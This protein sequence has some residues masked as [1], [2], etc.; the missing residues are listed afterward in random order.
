LL[1]LGRLKDA[2]PV[3][4]ERRRLAPDAYASHANLGTLYT[5]TGEWSKALEAIDKALTIE[6][7]AHFGREKYHFQLVVFL[8]DVRDDP[9]LA[10]RENFLRI[11]V[12]AR[13]RLAGSKE[14]FARAGGDDAMFDAL[15]SM[16][17]VYGADRVSHVYFAL[18]EILALRGMTRLAWT[19]YQRAVELKHPR[20][21]EIREWQKRLS[22]AMKADYDKDPKAWAEKAQEYAGLP[23]PYRKTHPEVPF[24]DIYE[25]IS[26][27]YSRIT[28]DIDPEWAHY[29]RNAEKFTAWERTEIAGGLPVWSE[30]G[31]AKIYARAN[32]LRPR[33]KSPGVVLNEATGQ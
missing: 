12:D 32:E 5:F 6:P 24:R 31:L 7:K 19:A 1:K 11:A 27:T 8:R 23:L 9:S 14:V 3:M 16:I 20:A 17:S 4:L 30:E 15:V 26:A 25:P 10:E 29:R 21:K 18:G 2:E 22:L 13:D 28:R 33:C